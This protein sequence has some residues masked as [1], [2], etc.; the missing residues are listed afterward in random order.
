M[1][2]NYENVKTVQN[3][4]NIF[5]FLWFKKAQKSI[6]SVNHSVRILQNWKR[7]NDIILMTA[8]FLLFITLKQQNRI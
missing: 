1:D 7:Q 3:V 8:C 2:K 4:E 6:R 5:F